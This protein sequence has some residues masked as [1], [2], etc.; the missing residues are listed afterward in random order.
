MQ[1]LLTTNSVLLQG[2]YIES[3]LIAN[4]EK[5]SWV[6]CVEF[7]LKHTGVSSK[8]AFHQH[9]SSIVKT[10]LINR[11]KNNLNST[12]VKYKDTIEGKLRTYALFKIHFQKE[13]YLSVIKDTEIRKC[14]ISFRI[15]SHKLEIERGRYKKLDL[16]DRPCKI[17]NTG[18]IEDE[19]HLLF[20]C[21]AYHSL[22]YSVM[23]KVGQTCKNFSILSQDAQL[24]WLMNNE[25]DDIINLF[26]RYIYDC[27]KLRDDFT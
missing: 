17:C 3:S 26:S 13:K 2:A 20:N 18:A 25:S 12:L 9:F 23:E 24:I 22:R 11:F 6:A 19:Q 1:R 14:F 4:N 8:L 15:S 16:K 10:N 5:M 7:I 27:F 21:S